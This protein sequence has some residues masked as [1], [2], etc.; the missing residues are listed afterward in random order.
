MV[1]FDF[2][3]DGAFNYG[4]KSNWIN[5]NFTSETSPARPRPA[6]FGFKSIT[7]LSRPLFRR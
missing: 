3:V 7:T 6:E 2:A 1:G 5:A 4:D